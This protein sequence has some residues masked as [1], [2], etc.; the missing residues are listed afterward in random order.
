[1]G[2]KRM[3]GRGRLTILK[4]FETGSLADGRKGCSGFS[5]L[6]PMMLCVLVRQRKVGNR[7]FAS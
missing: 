1:M 6:V 5:P 2:E 3:E 7:C 4:A